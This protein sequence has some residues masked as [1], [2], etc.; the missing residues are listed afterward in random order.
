MIKTNTR[1]LNYGQSMKYMGIHS[2]TTLNKMI[3]NGLPIIK[4][5]GVKRIDKEQ[6]DKYLKS[7]T[8]K[9]V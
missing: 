9:E 1:Y 5:G 8:I 4:I 6:L 7:K 2:Y 3:S